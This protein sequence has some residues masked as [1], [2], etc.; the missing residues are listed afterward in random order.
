MVLGFE[1]LHREA[2]AGQPAGLTNVELDDG[3]VLPRVGVVEGDLQWRGGEIAPEPQH[4][5]RQWVTDAVG[6]GVL[7]VL[8]E[9]VR[10]GVD[11][12]AR[13]GIGVQRERVLPVVFEIRI[14]MQNMASEMPEA[15]VEAVK[16]VA[17]L[18]ANFFDNVLIEVVEEFFAG[19]A[20]LGVDLFFQVVLKLIKLELD[21][22]SRATLL[23]DVGDA[24]LEVHAGFDS[25]EH[26]VAGAEYTAEER[27]LLVEQFIDA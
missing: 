18:D 25:A 3:D 20:L 22:F 2:R 27:E 9:A 12:L 26:L 11:G 10:T 5:L 21:L 14:V 8:G 7:D 15:L 1:R 13:E 24:L 4:A 16:G 17:G 19:V 23:I 6:V